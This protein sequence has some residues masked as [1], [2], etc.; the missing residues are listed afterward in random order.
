[1]MDDRQLARIRFLSSRFLELQ[2]LRVALAGATMATVFGSYLVA[3]QPTHTGGMIALVVSFALMAPGQWWAHRFYATTVGR[4][5]RSRRN[6]WP[7]LIFMSVYFVIGMYLNRR[8]PEI[9]AGAPT[10]ATVVLASLIIA[11]RDWPW[12][13]HYA[14]V[15]VIVAFAFSS[16]VFGVDVIDRGLALTMTFFAAGISFT[17]VGLLDHRLLMTLMR[18]V[19]LPEAAVSESHPDR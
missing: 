8:Y 16:N 13:A 1:M 14:G 10:A 12:R 3:A 18:E 4:Q 15:T 2:G 9:P 6:L 19:R 5:V 11:V 17:L 7:S